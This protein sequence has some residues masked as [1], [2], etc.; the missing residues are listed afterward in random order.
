MSD[1]HPHNLP[2][3][4]NSYEH[5]RSE[6]FGLPDDYFSSFHSRLMGKIKGEDELADF[7]LLQQAGKKLPFL[8]PE[9][10]FEH[11]EQKAELIPYHHLYTQEK[12]LPWHLP[13]DYFNQ[14]LAQI[15]LKIE[16]CQYPSLNEISKE[17]GFT[18]P[19]HYWTNRDFSQAATLSVH[20]Q[21]ATRIIPL[22]KKNPLSFAAAASILCLFIFGVIY[23][24]QSKKDTN[25]CQQM[26]CLEKGDI[27]NHSGFHQ[28][29][30]MED[31]LPLI[32]TEKL[33][34]DLQEKMVNP[35]DSAMQQVLDQ[36]D[37]STIEDE[38]N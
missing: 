29:L 10:Y 34:K 22:W 13:S 20:R 8:V 27:L 15:E 24:T 1:N 28:Q 11:Q 17:T 12:S 2:E 18:L 35:T 7:P 3:D 14:S 30:E 25:T 23:L 31:L 36:L 6:G 32:D 9:R 4:E 26:A 19:E 33:E 37:V 38:I 21:S 5:S 16:R